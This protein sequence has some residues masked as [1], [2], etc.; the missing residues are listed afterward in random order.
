MVASQSFG[1]KLEIE[2]TRF[3]LTKH[4]KNEYQGGRG[5]WTVYYTSPQ[6]FRI[7]FS[8]LFAQQLW[9]L[10]LNFD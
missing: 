4:Q 2:F 8:Y 6:S 9:G 7:T 10:L 5:H 1:A 3:W